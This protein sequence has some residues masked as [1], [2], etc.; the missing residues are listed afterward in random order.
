MGLKIKL[1]KRNWKWFLMY[2]QTR[3]LSL[4]IWLWKYNFGTFWGPGILSIPKL[5]QFPWSK[6]ILGQ[7]F[8]F[9]GPLKSKSHNPT[10]LNMLYI[11]MI[12]DYKKFM[13]PTKGLTMSSYLLTLNWL[14]QRTLLKIFGEGLPVFILYFLQTSVIFR[15]LNSKTA[16]WFVESLSEGFGGKKIKSLELELLL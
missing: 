3:V 14:K 9:L 7:K 6:L 8:W 11:Y 5:Q 12:V 15:F 2:Q 13:W 1:P 16:S 4:E 10:D